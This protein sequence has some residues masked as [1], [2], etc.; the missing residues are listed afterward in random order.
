MQTGEGGVKK[1]ENFAEVICTCPL[2]QINYLSP[3]ELLDELGL[4]MRMLAS[5]VQ[6]VGQRGRRDEHV[7][8]QW[9]E[10]GVALVHW[11]FLQTLQGQLILPV[12][13][14]ASCGQ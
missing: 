6:I 2:N 14:V 4:A 8:H 13:V 3:E 10:R 7:S 5:D 12:V 1:S 11:R 9:K